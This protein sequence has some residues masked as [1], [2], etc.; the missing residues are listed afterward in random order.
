ML[1]QLKGGLIVSCQALPDEPLHSS[2][3]MGRMALAA[4]EGGAIGIRAQSRE[5]ILEIEKNVTLPIIGIVK[6]N[7][8]DSEIYITPTIRE[9]KELL[10]TR[11]EIIALD[12]TNRKRPHGEQM[13]DLVKMIHQNHRLAMA[14]CSTFEECLDAEKMGFD[15]VSTTLA[16]YTPYSKRLD[17]PDFALIKKC[18]SQLYVPVIAEGRIHTPTELH[19]VLS[20]C[21]AY[22]A[23]IGGAITRPKEITERFIKAI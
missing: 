3:I 15:L 1:E 4:K 10:D 9:I 11:C 14:D 8:P 21:G 23:V 19:K 22:A 20:E 16:G 5:D 17:G 13:E 18:T 2:F 12:A 6:R 7:Y